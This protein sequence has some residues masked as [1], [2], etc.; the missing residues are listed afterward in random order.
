[1]AKKSSSL[2]P[3]KFGYGPVRNRTP[4]Q[5]K[6]LLRRVKA[7]QEVLAKRNKIN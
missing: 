7:L 5:K 2:D 3:K 1:M 4:V 6:A